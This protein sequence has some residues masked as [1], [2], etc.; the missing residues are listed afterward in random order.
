MG[1]GLHEALLKARFEEGADVGRIDVLVGIADEAGL[2]VTE[3]KAVLDVDRHAGTVSDLRH[4]AEM[5][6]ISRTPTL[7]IGTASLEGPARIDDLRGF[8]E[9]ALPV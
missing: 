7:R 6:G 1:A 9:G 2:D 3:S 5:A 4:R 8:L